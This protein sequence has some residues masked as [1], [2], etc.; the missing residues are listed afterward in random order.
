[1]FFVILFCSPPLNYIPSL[2]K[3][4]NLRIILLIF[5]YSSIFIYSIGRKTYKLTCAFVSVII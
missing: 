2:C 4:I 3:Q 5:A 1:M